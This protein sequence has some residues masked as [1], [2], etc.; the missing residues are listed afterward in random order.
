VGK[1]CIGNGDCASGACSAGTCQAGGG[2]TFSG[3][4]SNVPDASILQGG[5]TLCYKD[6]YGNYLD[7]GAIENNCNK[8]VLLVACRPS[9]SSVNTIAAMGLRSDVLYPVPMPINYDLAQLS[10]THLHNNVQWY[11]T[12]N[13]SMGFAPE[14]VVVARFSCDV[15]DWY[16]NNG[17][18]EGR[19]CWHWGGSGYRCSTSILD[20]S[21]ERVVYHRA[22]GL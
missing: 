11:Y 13:W 10:I 15:G 3:V 21:Y 18:P 9:G 5:F 6:T 2:L 8:G 1:A 22:G 4:Q 12:Q 7:N 14:G 17:N 16:F 19:L 20:T